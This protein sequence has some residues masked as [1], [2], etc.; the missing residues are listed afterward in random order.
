MDRVN[1]GGKW[2]EFL[3]KYRYVI[4]VVFLGLLLMA[5]PNH[6]EEQ[7]APEETIPHVQS[8]EEALEDILRRISGVGDVKVLLTV[9]AGEETLYQTDDEDTVNGQGQTVRK[10]TVIIAGTD[11]AQQG[12]IRQVNPVRYLGAVIVCDGADRAEVRLAIV[13][14]VSKATGL[15]ADKISVLKM[16]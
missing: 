14:A 5:I 12:L 10:D 16:K 8:T 9:A 11:R 3:K 6:K 13:D 4:L 2:K 7:E 1:I 15:G